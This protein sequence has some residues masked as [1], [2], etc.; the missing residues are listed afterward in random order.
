MIAQIALAVAV[1]SVVM[2]GWALE[3]TLRTAARIEETAEKLDRL[4][5]DLR[6]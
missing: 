6:G 3:V 2:A 4:D 5:K 1:A